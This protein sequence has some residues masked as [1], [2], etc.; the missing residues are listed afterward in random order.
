MIVFF[1]H[2]QITTGAYNITIVN[3]F[4]NLGRIFVDFIKFYGLQFDSTKC[5]IFV[6]SPNHEQ[7]DQESLNFIVRIH[8]NL[9]LFS[10][11]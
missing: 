1:F 6:P 2:V 9:I 8:I 3:D 7:P 5:V 10:A 11:Y 4:S